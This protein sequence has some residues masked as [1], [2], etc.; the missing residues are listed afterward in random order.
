MS[1]DGLQAHLM[2]LKRKRDKIQLANFKLF[3]LT[4]DLPPSMKP[5]AQNRKLLEHDA[6]KAMSE[7]TENFFDE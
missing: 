4:P 5:P 2:R 6:Q 7:E 1:W 3:E